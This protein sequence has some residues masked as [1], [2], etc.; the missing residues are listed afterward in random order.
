VDA[1]LYRSK[2][3]GTGMPELVCKISTSTTGCFACPFA[4]PL[5]FNTYEY[6]VL[7]TPQRS[8]SAAGWPA[9]R[10]LRIE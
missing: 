3:C 8:S 5:D 6:Y 7:V 1:G 10:S 9:L 4:P 2:R